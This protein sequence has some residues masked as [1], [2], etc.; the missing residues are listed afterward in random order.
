MNARTRAAVKGIMAD[1]ASWVK[2]L[3]EMAAGVK[4]RSSAER[5]EQAVRE[6]GQLMIAKVF[7]GLLQAA[8]D[9]LQVERRCPRCGHW[10][11]N[12]GSRERGLLSSVGAVKLRGPYFYC[13]Q[14]GHGQHVLDLLAPASSSRA[15]TEL[16]C[17]LGTA[18]G[19]F[20]QAAQ[21]SQ[22]LLG[23]RVS[24]ELIRVKCLEEGRQ[25]QS[26]GPAR[27][28]EPRQD[29]TVS[30]DGTMVNTREEK[31]RELKAHRLE[32]SGGVH[33]RAYLESAERFMPR[34]RQAAMA[35][36]AAR[37]GRIFAVSDAAEWI[38][39][40][41]EAQLPDA[42][43]IVDIWH[44][45]QHVHDAAR[46]LYGDGTPKAAT[47]GRKWCEHLRKHGGRVTWWSL[48]RVRLKDPERQEALA[49]LLGYLDRNAGRMD[50]PTYE[51][52]GYP[53]SSG[54][55]ESYCKQ[56]GRRLKGPGMRWRGANVM[57]MATLVSLWANDEWQAYW[58]KTA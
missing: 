24:D 33:G 12:K 23:V 10:W 38:D 40:G 44:A 54:P 1:V 19:S 26:V 27:R 45:Y 46:K 15:M 20:A 35:I 43:R 57:P 34:V 36:G 4:D 18:F 7:E 37:A 55:M 58:H 25:A 3:G 22:K 39:K 6:G 21:A 5:L 42:I 51:R 29:L 47:W 50:Y 9:G 2:G 11:H 32:H 17:L 14:C 28:L 52:L 49:A 31:W 53:I 56:L 13:A 16:L 30:C 8:V 48:R 41:F